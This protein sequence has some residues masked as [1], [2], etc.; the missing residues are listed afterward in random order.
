MEH[1]KAFVIKGVMSFIILYF[2]LGLGFHAGFGDLLLI[3]LLLGLLSYIA[4]DLMILPKTSNLTAT[5]S[6]FILSF[7]MIWGLG[8]I[9]FDYTDSLMAG[10]LFAAFLIAMGEWF[11]HSYMADKVLRINRKI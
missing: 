9:L 11:F 8:L 10:S 7:F 5:A 3:T 2:V 1:V 4:G 6:D